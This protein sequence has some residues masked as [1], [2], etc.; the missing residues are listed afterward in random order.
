VRSALAALFA[1]VAALAGAGA[2]AKCAIELL[3]D[4]PVTMEGTVPLVHAQIN[5]RDALFIADSGSFFNLVTPEAASELQ[6]K[7]DASIPGLAVM[8][9]GG[10]ERAQLGWAKTFT[11]MN[12]T[13][14][15]VPFFV[16]FRRLHH[17]AGV[18]GQNVFRLADVEYDLANG[19]VRLVQTNKDKDCRS[20]PFAYWA[21]AAGKPYSVIDIDFATAQAPHTKGVAYLNGNKIH[22]MFDTGAATSMVSLSAAKRAGVTPQTEG[23]QPGGIAGGVGGRVNKTWIGRF[24]SFRLG[25]EE[26]QH[27]RLRF[28]DIDL[29]GADML[30]GADFFLSHR[31]FVASS[32]HKLYFTYNGGAVF[33]LD[34]NGALPDDAA[35]APEDAAAPPPPS[36]V[37]AEAPAAGAPAQPSPPGGK[38]LDEPTDA[39]GFARRAAAS[40]GRHEYASAL[41]DLDRA[42]ALAPTDSSYLYQRAMVHWQNRQQELALTDLDQALKLKSDDVDALVARATL[43][44]GHHDAAG[45]TTDL[46]AADR[47]AAR[48]ADER[49]HI[50]V[51]YESLGN[52]TAAR[53]Q[54]SKWIDAHPREDSRMAAVLNARCWEGALAG[55]ALEQALADCDAALRRQP[56][57]AAFLDSRGLVYLRLADYD[58]AIKDYDA[59]LKIDP[60]IVWSLYGRG[61]ARLRKGQTAAGEADLAAAAALQP[62]I[63][64]RAAKFGLTP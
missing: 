8:G 38:W 21:A 52:A 51:L 4:I 19:V 35:A 46:E 22:V 62:K 41:G 61:L 57:A 5:G 56:N 64:E 24:A 16:S 43:R 13:V 48:D 7:M 31:I 60:Q 28:A 45:A 26:I 20:T 58:K 49:L 34:T 29:L 23:V 40:A 11:I 55:Q 36:A 59:A 1:A 50:A 44:A 3:P 6:L 42:C 17:A 25:D 27:A 53:E 15:D 32:Q 9:A 30:I 33:D 2:Q 18:L 10:A 39:E 63:A 12:V 14:H 54:D 37:A 47:S